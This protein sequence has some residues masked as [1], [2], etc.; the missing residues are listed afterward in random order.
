MLQHT[1]A[2]TTRDKKHI[3]SSDNTT[4][5]TSLPP[6]NKRSCMKF[7]LKALLITACL[8]TFSAHYAM[9][10]DGDDTTADGQESCFVIYIANP[11]IHCKFYTFVENGADEKS[12]ERY[13]ASEN[14]NSTDKSTKGTDDINK[15]ED[16]EFEKLCKSVTKIIENSTYYSY[17]DHFQPEIPPNRKL[18]NYHYYTMPY[19]LLM[20]NP[21]QNAK[22]VV[23]ELIESTYSTKVC[24]GQNQIQQLKKHL[25]E[26]YTM[27][28]TQEN[29]DYCCIL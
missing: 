1:L 11:K 22:D 19:Y 6:T 14:Y 23:K 15:N 3:V 26:I 4:S 12:W 29:D 7:Y 9:E 16:N 10:I 8:T 25:I 17:I 18:V 21:P 24:A 2:F 20:L 5:L 27:P 28:K 13:N